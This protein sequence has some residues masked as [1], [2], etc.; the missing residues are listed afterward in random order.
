MKSPHFLLLPRTLQIFIPDEAIWTRTN[1]G[2]PWD[3]T[4]WT[5]T[6]P[7]T[8]S[9]SVDLNTAGRIVIILSLALHLLG[10]G[11]TAI[12]LLDQEQPVHRDDCSYDNMMTRATGHYAPVWSHSRVCV[13]SNHGNGL[14]DISWCTLSVSEES[15]LCSREFKWS[16]I[17]QPYCRAL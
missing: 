4:E 16:V 17:Q 12:N 15:C 14:V 5:F 10:H 1:S 3:M 8:E 11:W 6:A 2:V 7:A 9:W 13:W